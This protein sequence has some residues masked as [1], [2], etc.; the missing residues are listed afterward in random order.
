MWV[1]SKLPRCGNPLC[2][3][4]HC[5][6]KCISAQLFNTYKAVPSS[7]KFMNENSSIL[8][9]IISLS[10]WFY[11]SSIK[12]NASCAAWGNGGKANIQK[13][14]QVTAWLIRIQLTNLICRRRS[15]FISWKAKT[16]YCSCIVLG[17]KKMA[18]KLTRNCHNYDTN[19]N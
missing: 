11:F 5:S 7:L 6:N 15:S 1:A 13:V 14:F 9:W 18:T 19:N 17:G 4:H 8:F 10:P 2:C 12:N 16:L 3:S